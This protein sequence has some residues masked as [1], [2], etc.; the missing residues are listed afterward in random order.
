MPDNPAQR[1]HT[2]LVSLKKDPKATEKQAWEHA[3]R[4]TGIHPLL[5]RVAE[6]SAL[7]GEVEHVLLDHP[8][9]KHY[10]RWT[11]EVWSLFTDLSLPQTGR[12]SSMLSELTLERL[13]NCAVRL[14]EMDLGPEIDDEGIAELVAALDDV[15]ALAAEGQEIDDDVKVFVAEQC[16]AIQD[17]LRAYARTGNRGLRLAT[18]ACIGRLLTSPGILAKAPPLVLQKFGKVI[19]RILNTVVTQTAVKQLQG[20]VEKLLS[21]GTP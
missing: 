15:K 20:V 4:V 5:Q 19:T 11:P 1:L 8:D 14:S 7:I 17:A 13:Q 3:L 10:M 18:E 2:I 6:T 12:V 21:S 9:R 16:T